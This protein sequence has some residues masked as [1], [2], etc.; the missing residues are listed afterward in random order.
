MIYT[1]TQKIKGSIKIVLAYVGEDIFRLG[2]YLFVDEEVLPDRELVDGLGDEKSAEEV[3]RRS[4]DVINKV[5]VG[6]V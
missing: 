3:G 1:G 5:L 4:W 2:A 6:R